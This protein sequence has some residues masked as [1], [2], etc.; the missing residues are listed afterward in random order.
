MNLPSSR[1]AGAAAIFGVAALAMVP[2]AQGA[3]MNGAVT[4]A[5]SPTTRALA[6]VP[7]KIKAGL[8]IRIAYRRYALCAAPLTCTAAKSWR[9][10]S[11]TVASSRR[12]APYSSAILRRCSA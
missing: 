4:A 10:C 5:A 8:D 9:C 2:T 11:C 7:P 3:V 12:H 1:V 6:L